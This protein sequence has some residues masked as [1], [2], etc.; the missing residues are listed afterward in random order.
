MDAKQCIVLDPLWKTE[1]LAFCTRSTA[2]PVCGDTPA[3]LG[4]AKSMEY[5]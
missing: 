1:L 3:M 5:F 4:I 2:S